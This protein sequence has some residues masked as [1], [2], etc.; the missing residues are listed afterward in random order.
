MLIR[1]CDVKLSAN[2]LAEVG[3]AAL[4]EILGIIAE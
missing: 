4:N 3:F 1:K 2:A